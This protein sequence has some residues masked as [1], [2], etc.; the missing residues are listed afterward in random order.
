[1]Y[2]IDRDS[3]EFVPAV[4]EVTVAGKPYNPTADPVEFAFTAVGA[5]PTTW[6]PGGWDGIDPIPGSNAYRA[7]VLA[8]PG[9]N[10]PVLAAGRYAVWIRITDNP[11]QPV[12]PVGQ[13]AVT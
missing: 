4:V 9:S 7:Q 10:G 8:G 3:R 2:S 12:L 5:R 13:L 6:Y 11:E 1:M